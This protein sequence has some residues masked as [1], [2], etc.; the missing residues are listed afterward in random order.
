M[1]LN[2][3]PNRVVRFLLVGGVNSLFGFSVF[4]G[5]ALLGASDLL[6][7]LAGNLAGL[8]FNF[9]STSRLVFRTL[10]L[11]RVPRFVLCYFV[12]L[13][14]NT[15]LLGWLGPLLDDRILVQAILTAP[16]AALSYVMM[17]RWVFRSVI[18]H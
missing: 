15:I 16:M 12:M 4:C 13:G 17:S 5:L 3:I 11:A 2:F 14:L 10:A 1:A 8:V 18:D 9:F 7:I 6:A